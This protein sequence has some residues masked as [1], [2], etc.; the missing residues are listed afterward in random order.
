M[1]VIFM[2]AILQMTVGMGF[3]MLAS[4]LIALVKPEI[5][6]GTIMIMGLVVG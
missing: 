4:P 1:G 3:G 6:P 5:V 2:A